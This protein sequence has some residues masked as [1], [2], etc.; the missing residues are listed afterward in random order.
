[1]QSFNSVKCATIYQFV[2]VG[3]KLVWTIGGKCSD[4]FECLC[5]EQRGVK[6]STHPKCLSLAQDFLTGEELQ[7]VS[8]C[9]CKSKTFEN[10][11]SSWFSENYSG[12]LD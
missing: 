11:K 10:H 12:P 8:S 6:L 5:F 9:T 3:Y 1:M 4:L 2:V 7:T